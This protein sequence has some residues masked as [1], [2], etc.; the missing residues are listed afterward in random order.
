MD[1]VQRQGVDLIA[2]LDTS[3]SMNAE[4]AAPSRLAKAKGEIRG[5]IGRLKGNRVGL[6]V[7]A[8][9]AVV[10]CPLTLDYGAAELLLD[11]ANT[12]IVHEPGTSLAAAIQTA[13]AAFIAKERR[14][15]VR[16]YS[17]SGFRLDRRV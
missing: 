16:A 3:Y 9:I 5:L 7:F 10:Q 8:G 2:A 15:K 4:D 1:T 13:T 6:L 12:E 14:Y 11:V 17:V